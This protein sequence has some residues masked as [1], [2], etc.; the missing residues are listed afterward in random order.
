MSTRPHVPPVG[1]SRAPAPRAPSR[2]EMLR[3]GVILGLAG[4]ASG[5]GALGPKGA[6]TLLE[7]DEQPLDTGDDLPQG[8][9]GGGGEDASEEPVDGLENF[10]PEA[11]REDSGRF[12]LAVQAGGMRSDRALFLTHVADGGEARLV[13][14]WEDEAGERQVVHNALHASVDDGCLRVSVEGLRPDTWHAYVFLTDD[15]AGGGDFPGRSIVGQVR[16]APEPG[17]RPP[18][19]LAMSACNGSLHDPWP[20]LSTAAAEDYDFFVHL[21]DMAYNDSAE[22]L[23]EYRE[24]WRWYLSGRGFRE[25]YA[26]A[27]LYA[28]WDD[29]EVTNNWTPESVSA[30]REGTALQAF[31]EHVAA[32]GS[33]EE[34]HWRSYRWGDTLELF[35]LDCRSERAPS[36]GQYVSEEQLEWLKE[37]LA[38]S[39]CHFKLVANSVP[40]TAMPWF[41]PSEDDRWEGFPDQRRELLDH[42]RDAGLRN[43]VFLSGDFHVC[44]VARVEEAGEGVLDDTWEIACTGGNTNPLGEGLARFYPD[45]FAYGVDEARAVLV[46]CDPAADRVRVTFIKGSSGDLDAEFELGDSP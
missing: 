36:A 35:L 46:H 44:F 30:S 24:S 22:S 6:P 11:I 1:P 45:Q 40:I 33:P 5:S 19:T 14:W 7:E 28:V 25:A 17:A 34:P 10:D 31:Y 32:E 20:A 21:G 39:P 9:G 26:R 4:C 27:G 2:R 29:H 43:V 12:P 38:S 13:V 18:L 42:I 23:D 41:F 8:G 15:P 37:G 16:T 3:S